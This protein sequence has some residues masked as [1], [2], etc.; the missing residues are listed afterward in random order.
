MEHYYPFQGEKLFC[1]D[2]DEF[3]YDLYVIESYDNRNSKY[4]VLAYL[5]DYDSCKYILDNYVT[6][7]QADIDCL[8]CMHPN[9]VVSCIDR[10]CLDL[11]GIK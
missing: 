8:S 7:A 2:S 11:L 1:R 10:S 3:D 6:L 9:N 5:F 4:L